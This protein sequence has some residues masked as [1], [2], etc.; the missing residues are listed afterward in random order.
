MATPVVVIL[1]QHGV[2][3]DQSACGGRIVRAFLL[4]QEG[5]LQSYL[6]QIDDGFGRRSNRTV[7]DAGTAASLIESWTLN[8]DAYV[9]APRSPPPLATTP[10]IGLA[11]AAAAPRKSTFRLMGAL[12]V[13]PAFAGTASYGGNV[14]G[15]ARLGAICLGARVRIARSQ[16]SSELAVNTNPGLVPM[17]PFLVPMNLTRTGGDL[18]AIAALPLSGRRLSVVPLVGLGAGWVHARRSLQNPLNSSWANWSFDDIALR[19]EA[20]L[21]G[22][23]AVSS[24]WSI[25]AELGAT[26]GRSISSFGRRISSNDLGDVATQVEPPPPSTTLRA[27]F[28]CQYTR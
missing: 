22:G 17:N 28:G 21:V 11:V 25:V 2:G 5:N 19:A 8:E 9:L 13:S 18:L 1:R 6:L 10:D 15:C 12:E 14:T 3:S 26:F 23:L 20:A 7:A 4:R 27:A 24:R 16:E